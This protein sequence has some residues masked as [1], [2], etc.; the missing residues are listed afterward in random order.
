MMDLGFCY[1]AIG[2]AMVILRGLLEM[3]GAG[4]PRPDRSALWMVPLGVLLWLP[5]LLWFGLKEFFDV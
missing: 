5:L 4:W 2:V 3:S 1:L